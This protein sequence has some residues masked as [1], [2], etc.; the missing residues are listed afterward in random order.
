MTEMLIAIAAMVII[1]LVLVY[2]DRRH[3]TVH[4]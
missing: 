4:H 3:K 2:L 1:S